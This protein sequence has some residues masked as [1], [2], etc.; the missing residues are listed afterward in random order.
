MVLP[1]ARLLP[2]TAVAGR[3]RKLAHPGKRIFTRNYMHV[4]SHRSRSVRHPPRSSFR[5]NTAAAR[6][7]DCFVGVPAWY[8]C[9]ASDGAARMSARRVRPP[10]AMS[11]SL[12]MSSS[13]ACRR[14][15]AGAAS[16]PRRRTDETVVRAG[17][18]LSSHVFFGLGLYIVYRGPD[19]PTFAGTRSG[20]NGPLRYA[21]ANRTTAAVRSRADHGGFEK[22][23]LT[24]RT[25]RQSIFRLA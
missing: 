12:V 7:D 16:I 24:P 3:G 11:R 8:A 2:R 18:T 23:G 6:A 10:L 4:R 5:S 15:S 13:S 19:H 22:C 21:E 25:R 1:I 14:P 20:L 9:R 17:R